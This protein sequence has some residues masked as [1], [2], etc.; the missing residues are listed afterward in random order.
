MDELEVVELDVVVLEVVEGVLHGGVQP[1]RLERLAGSRRSSLVVVPWHAWPSS[2]PYS[3]GGRVSGR[4]WGGRA[5][6]GRAP[7]C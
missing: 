2:R 4:G 3:R 7:A 6:P 5:G 1:Q